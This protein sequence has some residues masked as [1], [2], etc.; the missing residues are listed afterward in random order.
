MYS[1]VSHWIH[2]NKNVAIWMKYLSLT[3]LKVVKM[4]TF[5]A[6]IDEDFIKITIF[7]FQCIV[8]WRKRTRCNA[9]NSALFIWFFRYS[10]DVKTSTSGRINPSYNQ[11][12]YLIQHIDIIHIFACL[13][14]LIFWP[15]GYMEVLLKYILNSWF[16]AW[17]F[18]AKL[19]FVLYVNNFVGQ[20]NKNR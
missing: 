17:A 19:L 2:W 13:P 6:A 8:V 5:S 16:L 20:W 1:Q 18:T 11:R 7:P 15:L 3:A 14:Y 9:C 4:T 12:L 10:L